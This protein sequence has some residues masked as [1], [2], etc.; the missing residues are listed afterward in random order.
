[1]AGLFTVILIGLA[2]ENLIFAT[3]EKKTIRRWGMQA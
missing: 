3:I 2:V 1:F